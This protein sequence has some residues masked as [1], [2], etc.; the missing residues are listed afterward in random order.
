MMSKMYRLKQQI[1]FIIE[2]DKLKHIL[3]K[4]KPIGSDRYENDAE[5]TWHLA[6][7]A[8]LLAE[9]ANEP[10]LDLQRTIRMLI[11]H[12]IV[13]IDAGDT[14]AY[15][16]KGYEDKAEREGKAAERLFG[17]LPPD[18]KEEFIALWQEFEETETPEAKY[19]AAIDRMQPMLLNLFNGGQSWK[20]NGITAERVFAR[21]KHIGEGSVTL[22]SYMEQMLQE[23]IDRGDLKRG[24]NGR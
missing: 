8:L 10:E 23:A 3:R 14:F 18:Q 2:A 15:D 1:E 13:E 21:N 11:I 17:I 12:D 5:H 16:V 20:E 4:T 22:W 6:M 19:A 9:H 24:E 7:M